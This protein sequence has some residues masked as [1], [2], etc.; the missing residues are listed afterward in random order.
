MLGK[1]AVED[2]EKMSRGDSSRC[3]ESQIRY[4]FVCQHKIVGTKFSR[5]PQ[6]R[7]LAWLAGDYARLRF[8]CFCLHL[9]GFA[10]SKGCRSQRLRNVRIGRFG[11]GLR[12]PA[13]RACGRKG[14]VGEG[15]GS[16][17]MS[18]KAK[19]HKTANRTSIQKAHKLPVQVVGGR[20]GK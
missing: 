8:Y 4:P 1:V 9:P 5:Q 3:K 16:D 7:L 14:L 17:R 10:V 12:K 2:S 20:V 15:V 13:G 6:R 11:E 18:H 19:W